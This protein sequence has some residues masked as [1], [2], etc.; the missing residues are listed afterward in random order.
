MSSK[1]VYLSGEFKWAKLQTPD[2][3]YEPKYTLDLYLDETSMTTFHDSGL[4]VQLRD[5]E[6]GKFIKLSRPVHKT[7][8]GEVLD[9]GP[10]EVLLKEGDEYVKF[11]GLVGNGSKGVVRLRT[12]DTR[13]GMGHEIV[14]VAVDSLVEYA[15][16][17]GSDEYPF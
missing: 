14:K 4:K 16:D 3:K 12:Y 13:K 2:T 15:G 5:G 17:G 1:T 10:P 11:D 8:R 7:V 6:D 9:I